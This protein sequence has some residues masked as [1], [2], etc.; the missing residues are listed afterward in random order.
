M[1]LSSGAPAGRAIELRSLGLRARGL[2]V[3]K[4]ASLRTHRQRILSVAPARRRSRALQQ[5]LAACVLAPARQAQRHAQRPALSLR[6]HLDRAQPLEH[7]PGHDLAAGP[8]RA[9]QHDHQL[10]VARPADAIEVAQFADQRPPDVLEG[11]LGQLAVVLA[12][13]LAHVVDHQQQAA[14]RRAVA[15]CP[16]DLLVQARAQVRRRQVRRPVAP[17]GAS[18]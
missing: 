7:A 12:R 9:R 5:V 10:M 8:I 3:R 11:L 4:R 15:F 2:P 14:Q 16:M 17:N 13:D 6:F 18:T 1:G